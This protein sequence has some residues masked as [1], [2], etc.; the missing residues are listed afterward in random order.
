MV[1]PDMDSKNASAAD[2]S[3]SENAKGREP[4][5]AIDSQ[6]RAVSTKACLKVSRRLRPA[7]LVTISETPIKAVTAAAPRKTCQS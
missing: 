3:S 2:M 5:P 6:L 4:K 1:T 7:R